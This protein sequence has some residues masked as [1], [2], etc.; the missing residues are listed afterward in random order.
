V[1][2]DATAP[3]TP[4]DHAV[5]APSAVA[6]R[7]QGL[8]KTYGALRA[9]DDLSLEVPTGSVFGI[10]GPNGAGKTTTFA[11]LAGLVTPTSGQAMVAGF[12]PSRRPYEVRARLGYMPD[13]LGVYDGLQVDEYLRF[14][15]GAYRVPRRTWAGATDG[16]LELVGLSHKRSAMVTTLSRGM[17]Q[18][19]S[20]ARALVHD[21]EVLI[22]DE[23]AS[24]L[25]PRARVELRQLIN[26]LHDLGKTIVISSHVLADLEEVCSHLAIMEMGRLLAQGSPTQIL[27]GLGGGRRVVIRFLDGSTEEHAVADLEAQRNLV[28]DLVV[29]G[30]DVI[31]CT[32]VGGLEDLFL[33]ITEGR[34]Q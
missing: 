31:E 3:P 34:V 24:G 29:Q 33:R 7:T 26:D 2:T 28:R 17:K 12:D 11:I 13:A 8:T 19:L 1:S 22:L 30:R 15:L 10:V 32:P 4:A 18:R 20:L 27:D 23:P 16:L 6:I 5:E 9:V 25:D 21:P 14:F